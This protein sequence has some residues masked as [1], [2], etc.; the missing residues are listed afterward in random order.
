MG[1]HGDG[2]GERWRGHVVP[3][4]PYKSLPCAEPARTARSSTSRSAGKAIK[5]RPFDMAQAQPGSH[6]CTDQ[7][8]P[9]GGALVAPLFTLSNQAQPSGSHRCTHAPAGAP[10]R[11]SSSPQPSSLPP[12]LSA[13]GG[14]SV[15]PLG[16]RLPLVAAAACSTC[17][18]Q[19]ASVPVCQCASVPVRCTC[20]AAS[21]VFCLPSGRASNDLQAAALVWQAY[22]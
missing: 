1:Q 20:P 7:Q 13:P 21:M 15:A 12:D 17:V 22:T 8:A 4:I 19:C 14:R 2:L 9:P 6:R 18:C 10:S 5:P 11:C 3:C 16:R